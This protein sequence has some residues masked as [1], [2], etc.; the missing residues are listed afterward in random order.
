MR[1]FRETPP[2][3]VLDTLERAKL[4]DWQADQKRL[5]EGTHEA[6]TEACESKSGKPSDAI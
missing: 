2:E 4:L 6:L 3:E 5:P 1:S